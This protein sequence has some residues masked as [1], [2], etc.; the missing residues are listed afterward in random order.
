[1]LKRNTCKINPNHS[2]EKGRAR[3][4][5]TLAIREPKE[6]QI[7]KK[8]N[9]PEAGFSAYINPQKEKEGGRDRYIILH[10]ERERRIEIFSA[11]RKFRKKK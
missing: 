7:I 1:M 11:K 6:T 9:C 3:W 2:I 8:H 10:Q 4:C 5:A